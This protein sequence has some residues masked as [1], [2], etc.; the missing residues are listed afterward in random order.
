M[1][2]QSM[3]YIVSE[4]ASQGEIFGECGVLRFVSKRLLFQYLS[5]FVY[6]LSQI[7]SRNTADL[8]REQRDESFG[9]FCRQLNIVTIETSFTEIWRWASINLKR[10]LNRRIKPVLLQAENLLLDSNLNIKI[11]DFGFSNFYTA[12]ELLSTWCGSPPYAAPEVFEGKKYTGPEIDIWVNWLP[13]E[14]FPIIFSDWNS[15]SR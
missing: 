3:I 10:F 1:E 8:T 2:S 15:L 6:M 9:R 5:I 7:I 13:C 12:G 11:A 4:F 14:T